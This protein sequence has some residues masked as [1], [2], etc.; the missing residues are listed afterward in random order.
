MKTFWKVSFWSRIMLKLVRKLRLNKLM[1]NVQRRRAVNRLQ[2][3]ELL[4][5]NSLRFLYLTKPFLRADVLNVKYNVSDF[6][7]HFKTSCRNKHPSLFLT[8][9]KGF[10]VAPSPYLACHVLC[11][12]S[13]QWLSTPL[14]SSMLVTK[15]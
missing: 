4:F 8:E 7:P 5:L 1:I 10:Q 14:G 9:V 2:G 11:V 12:C 15:G 3:A 6:Y 13:C